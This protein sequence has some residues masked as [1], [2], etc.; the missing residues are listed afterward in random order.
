M[1]R[2]TKKLKTTG[3]DHNIRSAIP[4]FEVTCSFLCSHVR[5][6]F[7]C[8][9]LA[10]VSTLATFSV[11]IALF[12]MA[13]C[14]QAVNNTKFRGSDAKNNIAYVNSQKTPLKTKILA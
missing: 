10:N 8:F 6:L 3:L 4:T 14:K 5:K 9:S 12:L 2:G 1:S 13:K 7:I 11:S